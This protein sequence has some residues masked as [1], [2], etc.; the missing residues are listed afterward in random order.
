MS[1]V[2]SYGWFYSALHVRALRIKV[3]RS[4]MSLVPSKE[5]VRLDAWTCKSMCSFVKMKTHKK[6]GSVV[7]RFEVFESIVFALLVHNISYT[8]FVYE[9]LALL[10]SG[11]FV[12]PEMVQHFFHQS[13]VIDIHMYFIYVEF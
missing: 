6:L 4:K 3:Y 12:H 1:R 9:K 2:P 8:I 5:K 11:Y 13:W 10:L 7:S